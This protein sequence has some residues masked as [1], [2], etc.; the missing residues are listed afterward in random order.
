MIVPDV[1]VE[2]L[3]L[4]EMVLFYGPKWLPFTRAAATVLKSSFNDRYYFWHH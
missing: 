2:L 4:N 1:K 3:L